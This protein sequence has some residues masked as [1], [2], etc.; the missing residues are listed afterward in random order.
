MKLLDRG[1]T[2]IE[3]IIGTFMFILMII[4]CY[5]VTARGLFNSPTIW[6]NEISLYL[7][8]AIILLGMAVNLRYKE[9]IQVTFLIANLKPTAKKFLNTFYL[10]VIL[11]FSVVV[12][13]YGYDYFAAALET[14]RRSSTLL[15][16]PLYIPYSIM[17]LS[18][19]LLGLEAV[20]QM[21]VLWTKKE[22]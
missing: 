19:L 9:H 6:A 10:L 18:G 22:A 17:P 2:V 7:L 4:I 5:D 12:I 8:Q 14:G 1:L 11:A 15:E 13:K 16:I 20:R 3:Y 21:I